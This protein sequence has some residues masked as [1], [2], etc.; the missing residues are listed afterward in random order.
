MRKPATL[1]CATLALAA[2]PIFGVM[3]WGPPDLGDLPW[4]RPGYGGLLLLVTP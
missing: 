1:L 4:N 3:L 2:L